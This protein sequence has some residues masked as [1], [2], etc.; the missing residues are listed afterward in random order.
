MKTLS[1]RLD[2]LEEQQAMNSE[3]NCTLGVVRGLQGIGEAIYFKECPNGRTV[4]INHDRALEMQG[5]G[6]ECGIKI[7]FGEE[8]LQMTTA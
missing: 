6:I 4:P 2:K 8:R 5:K 7:N 3:T 1:K